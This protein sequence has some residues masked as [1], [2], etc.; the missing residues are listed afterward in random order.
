MKVATF[1]ANSMRARLPII[2]GWLERE[3]PDVLFLQETKVQDGDF[4]V[5]AVG[6]G[7]LPSGVS[8]AEILQRGWPF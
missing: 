4:P 7:R 2:L 6:G 8:R 3:A 1:N 5:K